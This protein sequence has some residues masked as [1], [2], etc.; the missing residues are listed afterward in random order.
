MDPRTL[1]EDGWTRQNVASEPRLGE[2]VEAYRKLGFE[3]LL[4]PVLEECRAEG[5]PGTCTACFGAGEDSTRYQVIY[6]RRRAG[7][8]EDDD[9][10]A[11]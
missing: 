11:P 6:T 2:A 9:P 8:C 1:V 5:E 3:V 10:F 4:V 7:P